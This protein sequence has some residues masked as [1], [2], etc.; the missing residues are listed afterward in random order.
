[1][2]D[3]NMA[4]NLAKTMQEREGVKYLVYECT[5][6]SYDIALLSKKDDLVKQGKIIKWPKND[7]KNK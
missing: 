1:M 7:I 4:I 5:C 2:K 6:C 3:L